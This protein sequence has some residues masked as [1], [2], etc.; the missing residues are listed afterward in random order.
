[1]AAVAVASPC[2]DECNAL[3]TELPQA[4]D[5][6]SYRMMLPRPKVGRACTSAYD[7]GAMTACVAVCENE[8]VPNKDGK[9]AE[10]CRPYITDYPKPTVHKACRTGYGLGFEKGLAA[11]QD[12]QNKPKDAAAPKAEAAK[13]AKAVEEKKN[14]AAPPAKKEEEEA[15]AAVAAAAKEE[16][17][18]ETEEPAAQRKL[19]VTM[20]VTVDDSEVHLEIYDDAEPAAQLD[21]FCGQYMSDSQESCVRQLTPHIQRKLKGE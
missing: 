9:S 21:A 1:V 19:L 5:C 7:S 11:A 13:T 8:E 2:K 4:L 12:A 15:P 3:A 17:E 18:E 14:E 6:R 16:E 20:P 10:F